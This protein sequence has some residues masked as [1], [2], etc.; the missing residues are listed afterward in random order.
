MARLYQAA[1]DVGEALDGCDVIGAVRVLS[2]LADDLFEW[3]Q[4][5]RPGRGREAAKVLGRLLAPFVP[6]LAEAIHR[7]LGGQ[8]VQSVHLDA[9]PSVDPSWQNEVIL[10]QMDLVKRLAALGKD[11]RKQAGLQAQRKLRQALVVLGSSD[12]GGAASLK[13]FYPLLAEAMTVGRVRFTAEAAALVG[14]RL[15]LDPERLA[16]RNVEEADLEAA[17]AGLAPEEKAA[18]VSQLGEGLSVR[19]TV[20]GQVLTLLPDEVQIVPEARAGWIAAA[21][22]DAGLLVVLETG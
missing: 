1:G 19:F 8:K 13:P 17:L 3:Y 14:W 5:H 4:P 6:H 22:V 16:T 12:E 11:A 21:D 7:Q 10:A 18:L 9:W 2:G 20:A 15:H